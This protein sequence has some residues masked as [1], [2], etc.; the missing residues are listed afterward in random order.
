MLEPGIDM[1]TFEYVGL[2]DTN[3]IGMLVLKLILKEIFWCTERYF[4]KLYNGGF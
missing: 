3:E 4:V 1:A 2:S